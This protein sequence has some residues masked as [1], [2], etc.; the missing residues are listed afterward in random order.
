MYEPLPNILFSVFLLVSMY[1]GAALIMISSCALLGAEF[2]MLKDDLA[3]VKPFNNND[4]GNSD[5]VDED[6]DKDDELTI[7]EF[8]KR[9]QKLLR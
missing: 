8:V 9:H 7:E 4:I 2:L 1:T 6:Y 3:H 5:D